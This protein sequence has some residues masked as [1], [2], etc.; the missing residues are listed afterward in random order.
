M[1]NKIQLMSMAAWCKRHGK[2]LEAGCLE[3]IRLYAGVFRSI[4]N[5]G[6]L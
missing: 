2:P 4:M 5:R 6:R 1:T 3:W